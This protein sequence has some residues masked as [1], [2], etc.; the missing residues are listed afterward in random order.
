MR[1]PFLLLVVLLTLCGG[2]RGTRVSIMGWE[3]GRA[4]KADSDFD[5]ELSAEDKLG[6]IVVLGAIVALGVVAATR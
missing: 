1:K 5:T 2:C 6:V 3:P 4:I